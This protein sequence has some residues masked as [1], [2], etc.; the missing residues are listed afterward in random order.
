MSCLHVLYYG[1]I[2]TIAKFPSCKPDAR[3]SLS[4]P[5]SFVGQ[6]DALARQRGLQVV[7]VYAA[8]ERVDDEELS[9]AVTRI[10]D[11]VA[12]HCPRA[13]CLLVSKRATGKG[14]GKA[15]CAAVL[16]HALLSLQGISSECACFTL[17]FTLTRSAVFIVVAGS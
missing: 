14:K 3:L 15:I 8:N 10:A 1:L 9:A 6:A 2:V 5:L 11:T 17:A 13:C 7:G 12:K 4:L 16:R